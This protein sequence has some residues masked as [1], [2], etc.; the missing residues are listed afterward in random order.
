VYAL[1]TS[2]GKKLWSYTTAGVVMAAP[3]V[4]DGV[5]YVDSLDSNVYALDGKTGAMLWSYTTHPGSY[6]NT[7]PAVANG[8]VYVGSEDRHIYAFGLPKKLAPQ[9]PKRPDPKALRPDFN[10]KPVS[11]TE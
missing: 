11:T 3:T 9:A 7:S 6:V 8:V 10:L 4:A 2:T 5:V 1:K